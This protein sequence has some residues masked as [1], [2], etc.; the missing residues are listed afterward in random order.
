MT[1][2]YVITSG[3]Y[4]A[5]GIDRVYLNKEDAKAYVNLRNKRGGNDHYKEYTVEEWEASD[6]SIEE[7]AE[8]N[9]TNG[10]WVHEYDSIFM[11]LESQS[12]IGVSEHSW[13]T[14][15]PVMQVFPIE[16]GPY[17]FTR[18]E[19]KERLQIH[20]PYDVA[21]DDPDVARKIAHDKFAEY[22]AAQA[23]IS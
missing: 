17:T 23:G 13:V 20:I 4:S 14:G 16:P 2:V 21:K 11:S 18:K 10:F 7:P 1:T 19:N 22:R 5:Y 12:N 3:D 6:G 9:R 8:E 15:D